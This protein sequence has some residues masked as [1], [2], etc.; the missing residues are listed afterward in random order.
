MFRLFGKK[1]EEPSAS[2]ALVPE[3]RAVA[4]TPAASSMA[5]DLADTASSFAEAA[6][7]TTGDSDTTLETE[8]AAILFANG[9]IDVAERMLLAATADAPGSPANPLAW[10]MLFDL[11]VASNQAERFDALSLTYARRFE[12]SPPVYPQAESTLPAH[13]T[14]R[15]GLPVISFS[16]VLDDNISRQIER[17]HTLRASQGAL[18]LDFAR[19]TA[20]TASGCE[21]LEQVLYQLSKEAFPVLLS[22]AEGMSEHIR[23]L[24]ADPG[25]TA[26]SACWLLLL[27]ILRLQ[28]QPQ[29][30]EDASMEYCIAFEVSPPTFVPPATPA[31]DLA[32]AA[33]PLLAARHTAFLMPPV[34]EGQIA[35]L[36]MALAAHVNQHEPALID[37]SRLNRVDFNAA[38]QLLSGLAPLAGRTVELHSVSHLVA[39]LLDVVGLKD[40]VRIVPRKH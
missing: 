27:E 35:P 31:H 16:G 15:P 4:R 29:A 21:L 22:G 18:R 3:R 37:C 11:Y 36:M 26:S 2:A 1:N 9:Q 24:I 5:G 38:G 19:V 17:L 10:W 32:G 14:A 23:T 12:R 8:E 39:I 13:G 34:L 40:L 6:L 20:V 25:Q 33:E 7:P 28:N 30:F